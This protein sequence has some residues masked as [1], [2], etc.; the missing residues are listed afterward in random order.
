MVGN[1]R[2]PVRFLQPITMGLAGTPMEGL[3]RLCC[4]MTQI[5]QKDLKLINQ[6]ICTLVAMLASSIQIKLDLCHIQV[7]KLIPK[8][9]LRYN[10]EHMI[11]DFIGIR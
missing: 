10:D 3:F 2:V 11:L 9:L 5:G 7:L 1:T 8:L 6:Q 4:L